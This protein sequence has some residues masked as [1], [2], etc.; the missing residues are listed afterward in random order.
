VATLNVFRDMGAFTRDSATGTYRVDFA[1][2]RTAVDSLSARILRLQG[3]GDY[4]A[5]QAFLAQQGT[6]PADL[7]QGLQHIAAKQIPVDIIFEQGGTDV[8]GG[9][10][11]AK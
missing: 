5:A 7:Q 9:T 10:P 2:M 4:A 3:D 1:K 11:T 6:I 8:A